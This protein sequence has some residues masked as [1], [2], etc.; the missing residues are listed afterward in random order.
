MVKNVG[1]KILLGALATTTAITLA[2]CSNDDNGDN[3]EETAATANENSGDNQDEKDGENQDSEN[4]DSAE[5]KEVETDKGPAIAESFEEL[6]AMKSDN[7]DVHKASDSVENFYRS[8]FCDK[9]DDPE[10]TVQTAQDEMLKAV[11]GDEA[12]FANQ[13]PRDA[14]S[15]L[16]KD[17]QKEL[18]KVTEKYT[19]EAKKHVNYDKLEDADKATLNIVILMFRSSMSAMGENM[20]NMKIAVDENKVTIDGD[21][22]AIKPN[23]IYFFNQDESQS[24]VITMDTPVVKADG[25]WRVDGSKFVENLL[26]ASDNQPAEGAE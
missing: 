7:D 10:G 20:D 22:G 26:S 24:I 5:N 18:V 23:Q 1:K 21:K 4:K 11:G 25:N 12:V 9:M 8:I 14:I 16:S 2:A 13:N 6:D 15:S 17:K 19:G 3:K